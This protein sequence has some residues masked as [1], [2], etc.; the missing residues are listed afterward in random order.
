MNLAGGSKTITFNGVPVVATRFCP[1]NSAYLLDSS[2]FHLHQL[3]DWTWLS[4][5]KGE[6]LHQRENYATHIAT[7]V[8]YCDLICDRPNR[9]LKL[10][11]TN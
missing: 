1:E 4:N 5:N 7:L 11:V 8:K 9:V 6:V 10:T 3:C 2:V